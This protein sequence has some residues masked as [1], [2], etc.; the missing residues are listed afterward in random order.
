MIDDVYPEPKQVKKYHSF[1]VPLYDKKNDRYK[2]SFRIHPVK[3]EKSIRKH[4]SGKTYE[5]CQ[6]CMFEKLVDH[7]E[8]NRINGQ[9]NDG[10]MQDL[11]LFKKTIKSAGL[12]RQVDDFIDKH[13]K[14]GSNWSKCRL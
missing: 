12:K 6:E 2:C 9:D 8:Q 11:E 7:F 4:A 3:G 13:T 5:I 1:T 10:I 14:S